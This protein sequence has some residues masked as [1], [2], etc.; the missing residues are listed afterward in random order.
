MTGDEKYKMSDNKNLTDCD[1]EK[2][3]VYKNY[4]YAIWFDKELGYRCG[5]V[6]IPDNHPLFEKFF[7][8]IHLID[9][10]LTFGG[11]IKGLDG[12][13]IGWDHHHLWE[14]IDVDSLKKVHINETEEKF[15]EII[16][17]AREM[18]G[19]SYGPYCTMDEVE[20]ECHNVIDEI[21]K[22]H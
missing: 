6:Q 20:E 4:R 5:Y 15:N 11:K 21:S 2:I 10:E 14:G 1:Y 8:D 7:G 18:A 9:V 16:E 17:H 3:D 13:F 22:M 19:N 12:W